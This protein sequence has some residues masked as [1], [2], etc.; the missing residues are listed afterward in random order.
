MSQGVT[1]GVKVRFDRIYE[2]LVKG[3]KQII[4][5]WLSERTPQASFFRI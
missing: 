5:D 1:I 4:S 3:Q 2:F